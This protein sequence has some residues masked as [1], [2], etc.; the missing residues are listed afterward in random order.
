MRAACLSIVL[1]FT[2]CG[3][4]P[5][6]SRPATGTPSPETPPESATDPAPPTTD[7][8][9]VPSD[10]PIVSFVATASHTGVALSLSNHGTSDVMVRTAVAVEIGHDEAF[11]PAPSSSTLSLRYD[12]THEAE[13]CV[14]LTP[15]AELLPPDWRGTWGDMQCDCTRCAPVEPGRYRLVVTTC[16]GTHRLESNAFDLPSTD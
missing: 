9:S 5:E 2:S 4:E 8:P 10:P 13:R 3:G 15:G 11:T 7:V 14:T 6:P 1:A 16:D 12:C